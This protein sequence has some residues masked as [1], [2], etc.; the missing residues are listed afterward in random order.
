M[1]LSQA[2]SS[3]DCF[4]STYVLDLLSEADIRRLMAEAHRILSPGGRVGLVSLTWGRIPLARLVS[5]LWRAVHRA[6]PRLVGGCRPLRLMD[7][8]PR[9]HWRAEY[10]NVVSSWGVSSEIIVA[11]RRE[12]AKPRAGNLW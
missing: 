6:T 4:V 10:R 5:R 3:F 1:E 2:D 8:L 12:T 11:Y 7:Y 9:T